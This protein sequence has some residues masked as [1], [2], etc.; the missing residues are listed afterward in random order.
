[1]KLSDIDFSHQHYRGY[2]IRCN[3]TKG[4]YIERGGI[5]VVDV[6]ADSSWRYARNF[7]DL[8]CMPLNYW[9]DGTN[10]GLDMRATDKKRSDS[11]IAMVQGDRRD[12]SVMAA[13][14]KFKCSGGSWYFDHQMSIA[15][16]DPY[17]SP[18]G[19]FEYSPADIWDTY[20]LTKFEADLLVNLNE[21]LVS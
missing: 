5:W 1:M 15:I 6:P 11:L 21:G 12:A 8:L 3:W 16:T 2:D 10:T 4:M 20:R 9:W 18:C 19:R 7:I 14:R 17:L 13:M